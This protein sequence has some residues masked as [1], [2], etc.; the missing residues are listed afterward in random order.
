MYTTFIFRAKMNSGV[1][2]ETNVST[3]LEKLK[4]QDLN[5]TRVHLQPLSMSVIGCDKNGRNL[6]ESSM[7][8]ESSELCA[9]SGDNIDRRSLMTTCRKWR[10]IKSPAIRTWG[11]NLNKCK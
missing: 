10:I 7:P 9:L 6:S 3:S 8:S 4:V 5:C 11:F 2:G 1:I